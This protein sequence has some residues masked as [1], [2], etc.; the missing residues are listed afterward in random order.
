MRNSGIEGIMN[1]KRFEDLDFFKEY[2]MIRRDGLMKLW[3]V[4]F[5]LFIGFN[6]ISVSYGASTKASGKKRLIV[7]DSYH[8]EYLW[9]QYTHEGFCEAMLKLGY[10]D[11]K[12][13]IAEYTKNDFVVSSRVVIKKLWMDSKRKNSKEEKAE[14]TSKLTKII[15]D[16]KP[17]LIFLGE[18][19]AADYIGNQ[20]LDLEIPIVFWGVNNTPV[21]YGLVDSADKPGH[22]VTGVYQTTYYTESLAF[23][24]KIVPSV[25][26]FAVLSD[27]T[28]TGRIFTKSIKHLARKGLLPLKL[29][30]TVSTNSFED[31]KKKAIELQN[32]VDAFFVAQYAGLKD[33]SGKSV[34][35]K[36][37]A[38][39]YVTHIKIPEAAG[40]KHRVVD[41]MLCAADDSGY[42][43]G[44]EAVVI[45]HDI[46]DRGA[47]PATYPPRAPKRGPLMVNKQRAKMLGITLTEEM[48]IE[49]Y[50]EEA[51]ALQNAK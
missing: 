29:I 41:G 14:T 26:T 11:N 49:E 24:K 10:F 5:T 18:D 37:T 44:H 15:Q 28:T 47:N 51:S 40:F 32:T 45:A 1:Y 3:R 50:I 36:E 35:D 19:N 31:W 23:L 21:K 48:G 46:L 27:N 39:W 4:L 2:K 12:D 9:S 25:K 8:R 7:V 16:F 22:N 13:Q 43:Q 30:E 6:L 20:Y 17:E 38:A 34:A 42:N 33:K